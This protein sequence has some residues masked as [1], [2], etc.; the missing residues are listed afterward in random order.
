MSTVNSGGL[1]NRT[2]TNLCADRRLIMLLLSIKYTV[3]FMEDVG[4]SWSLN[5]QNVFLVWL[6]LANVLVY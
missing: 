5:W 1:C 2:D 6:F 4:K 3:R